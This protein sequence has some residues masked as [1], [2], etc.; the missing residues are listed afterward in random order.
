V[1]RPVWQ[2][3][4]IRDTNAPFVLVREA[5]LDKT[6]YRKWNSRHHSVLPEIL[7]DAECFEV[8]CCVCGFFIYEEAWYRAEPTGER[9]LLTYRNRFKGWPVLPMMGWWRI[10]SQR[11]WE[12]FIASLSQ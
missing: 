11:I 3:E 5:L 8:R 2:F 10:K 1:K 12:R 4:L 6:N 9:V 7:E